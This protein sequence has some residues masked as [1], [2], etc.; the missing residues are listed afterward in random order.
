MKK[1]MEKCKKESKYASFNA[2]KFL[3]VLAQKLDKYTYLSLSCKRSQDLVS[4]FLPQRN[5]VNAKNS[6]TNGNK[7]KVNIYI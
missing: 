2:G 4:M 3:Q 5:A 6:N 7:Q 1:R